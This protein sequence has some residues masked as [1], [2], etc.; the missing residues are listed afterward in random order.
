MI[1]WSILD[2]LNIWKREAA[3][4]TVS[5]I[6]S[7]FLLG[8]TVVLF[9]F[10]SLIYVLDIIICINETKYSSLHIRVL[11]I[12]DQSKSGIFWVIIKVYLGILNLWWCKFYTLRPITM[13]EVQFRILNDILN[14]KGI[15]DSIML[16]I[17]IRDPIML[18]IKLIVKICL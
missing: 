1:F 8:V 17:E 6:I 9:N 12:L 3:L 18:N 5:H 2:I 15:R 11:F 13:L 4:N 16:Y 10:F 7:K 14:I